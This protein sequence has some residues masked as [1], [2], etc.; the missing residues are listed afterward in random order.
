MKRM[1]KLLGSVCL[2]LVLGA[3]A[4]AAGTMIGAGIGSATGDT[5]TGALIGGGVGMMI[6]VFN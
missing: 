3:C 6:D 1:S 2:V 4:T 5:K